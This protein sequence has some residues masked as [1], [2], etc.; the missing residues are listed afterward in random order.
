MLQIKTIRCF[1]DE[2]CK[3]YALSDCSVYLNSELYYGSAVDDELL[4]EYA[5]LDTPRYYVTDSDRLSL[6]HTV[7]VRSR[8]V[9]HAETSARNSVLFVLSSSKRNAWD[10]VTA[11]SILRELI[12]FKKYFE[13]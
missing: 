8:F 6:L 5:K 7:D 12:E 9:F 11:E 4:I 10:N 2:L 3:K 1:A 13:Q